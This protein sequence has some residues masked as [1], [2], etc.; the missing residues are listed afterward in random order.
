MK[1]RQ[2]YENDFKNT[3]VPAG[4]EGHIRAQ[5]DIL[6]DI[7]D[8]LMAINDRAVLKE[9]TNERIKAEQERITK[10]ADMMED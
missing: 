3:L 5:L 10:I 8:L 6:L 1:S 4:E 9:I 7:R 2:D